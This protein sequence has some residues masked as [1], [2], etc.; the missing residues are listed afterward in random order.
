[1]RNNGVRSGALLD[2]VCA[3]NGAERTEIG[4][5]RLSYRLELTPEQQTLFDDLKSV[6]PHRADPVRRPVQQARRARCRCRRRPAR[7]AQLPSSA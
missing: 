6:G 1:M 5:V 4:F 3:D 2:L 7:P